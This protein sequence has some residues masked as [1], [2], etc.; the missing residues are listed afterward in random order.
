MRIGVIDS[1][2]GGLSILSAVRQLVPA[3]Y[4]YCMDN[5]YFPY[6]TKSESF[7][8]QRLLQLTRYLNTSHQVELVVIAC[9]TAT[10]QAVDYLRGQCELPFVGVVPA[11][12]PA[13][14]YCKDAPFTV[15]ATKGTVE[16]PYLRQLVQQFSPN[17]AVQL[18]GASELV[19]LAEQKVWYGDAV[20]QAVTEVVEAEGIK[21]HQSKAV[22]LGCTH[23]P[24]LAKELQHS[25]GKD[26]QLFDTADAIARRV[27]VLTEQKVM[28]KAE[29]DTDLFITT[30]PLDRKQQHRLSV[31]GFGQHI[32]WPEKAK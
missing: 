26:V 12:K 16:G 23:F 1:G 15:L 6:G 28:Q 5:G 18:I 7:I 13:A 8:R 3:H 2:V 11:I 19:T 30:A 27:K 9:N 25:L 32:C 10:T 24:F 21:A 22:V 17:N 29:N 4:I 20:Q 14:E 31:L